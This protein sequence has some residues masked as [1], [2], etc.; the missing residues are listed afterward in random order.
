MDFTKHHEL[1][2]HFSTNDINYPWKHT[3]QKAGMFS[4]FLVT[5]PILIEISSL[6]FVPS[7]QPGS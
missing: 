1:A 6:Y 4:F 2:A 3:G 7:I 5:S